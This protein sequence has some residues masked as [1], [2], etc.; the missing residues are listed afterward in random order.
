[1]RKLVICIVLVIGLLALNGCSSSALK[2]AEFLTSADHWWFYDEVTGES[3]KMSFNED[4]S[5][6]WCC[7]CGEPV[8]NSDLYECFEFDR[9]TQMI[10]L[11]NGYDDT[12]MEMKVLDYNDYYL[13][14]D[15]E[16]EIRGYTSMD[17]MEYEPHTEN[18]EGYLAGYNMYGW[19]TENYDNKVVVGPFNYDGDIEYPENAF[20]EYVLADDAEFYDYSIK[21]I[22]DVQTGE[23]D[24]AE[25]YTELSGEDA[26][27]MLESGL[28]FIWFND[29]MEIEKVVFYGSLLIQE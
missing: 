5:F 26:M 11:Y 6:F 1:M 17:G 10:R 12:S 14:L 16:G 20:N 7:E 27:A 18:T 4:G 24:V 8:G 25:N 3:E 15:V 19:F 13:L 23:E 2:G 29:A 21:V 28:G 22:Q 9:D